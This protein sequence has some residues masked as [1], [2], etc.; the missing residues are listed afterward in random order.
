MISGKI[1]TLGALENGSVLDVG[2]DAADGGGEGT[3]FDGVDE[4][5]SICTVS[6]T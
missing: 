6:G 2:D 3:V 5:L 1:V 4:G